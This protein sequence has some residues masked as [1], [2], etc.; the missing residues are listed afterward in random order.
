MSDFLK[1]LSVFAVIII[2]AR[3]KVN[4]GT[5]MVTA[6]VVLGLLFELSLGEL[7]AVVRSS[8]TAPST[9]NLAAAL[10]LVMFLERIMRQQLIM[11]RLVNSLKSLVG[12]S[13]AVMAMLP[14]LVGLL[15]SPGGA[16][17]SAP[18]VEEVSQ[19]MEIT[20]ERKS[21]INYW[22]RHLWEFFFPLWPAILLAAEIFDVP[23]RDLIAVQIPFTIAAIVVGIPTAF[24]GVANC[25]TRDLN[26][27]HE[28]RR[29]HLL[30]LA[31]GIGP[32]VMVIA[33]VLLAKLEISVSIGAVVLALLLLYRY[34]PRRLAE[35]AKEALAP[36]VIILAIGVILFKNML[37]A[38]GAVEALSSFFTSL[39]IPILLIFFALPFI[40][41]LL[42]GISLGFVGATFPLFLGLLGSSSLD[43]RLI[44]FAFASGCAGVMLSPLHLCLV[45]TVQYFE[46][47]FD[48]VY[49]MLIIPEVVMVLIAAALYFLA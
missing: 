18:M 15:P 48:R 46:A 39:G 9:L 25:L 28:T 31:V 38:C 27:N 7:L 8:I 2:L 29:Q 33:L 19:G 13:R 32:V 3:K 11:Q 47:D 41:G 36:G 21:F 20:P 5:V 14:A 12:D 26:G 42:T 40:V 10:V 4:L 35:L 1:V 44:A 30:D 23:V 45:L 34:S 16:L 37:V 17:F 6:A 49:R 24:G 22:Y 43:L